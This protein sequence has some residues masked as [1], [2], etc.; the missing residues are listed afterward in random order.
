M[1]E[2]PECHQD[3]S[4]RDVMLRHQRGKHKSMAPPPSPLIRSEAYPPPQLMRSEAY[5]PPPTPPL[6]RSEAFPPPPPLM[7]SEA[8]P[9]PPPPPLMRSEAYPPQPPPPP[10]DPPMTLLQ[11]P[12]TMMIFGP[13]DKGNHCHLFGEKKEK[14]QQA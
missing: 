5:P 9:P 2:C 7:R 1:N 11:H 14:K 12:F 6:M 3:F 8:Y 10:Q 13:T 4:T